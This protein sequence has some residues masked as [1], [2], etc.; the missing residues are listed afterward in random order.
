MS[1]E[2]R[3]IF[4]KAL[5]NDV[6]LRKELELTQQIKTAFERKGEMKAVNEMKNLTKEQMETIIKET[7][8]NSGKKKS[9]KAIPL[10]ITLVAIAA[11]AAIVVYLAI[12]PVYTTQDL[13]TEYYETTPYET[14]PY[15]GGTPMDAE[16]DSLLDVASSF[17]KSGD[18]SMALK[19]F[20]D[21]TK[22]MHMESTPDEVIFYSGMAMMETGN[23]PDAIEQFSY[24]ET[25]QE[26][27]FQQDAAWNLA[28]AYLRNGQREEARVTLELLVEDNDYYSEQAKDLL[29][30]LNE[31]KWF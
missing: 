25:S 6:G 7:E 10:I 16:K 22:D 11:V 23:I 14:V 5:L 21:I 31:K 29:M 9:N 4:E 17:Y 30:K 1:S 13:F 28:M 19:L 3:E 18:Y 24:L 27:D 26:S 15:R 20:K 8:N 2:E 12:Q